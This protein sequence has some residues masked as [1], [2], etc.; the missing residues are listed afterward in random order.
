MDCVRRKRTAKEREKK[1][2]RLIKIVV[3]QVG[4]LSA[5]IGIGLVDLHLLGNFRIV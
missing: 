3:S 1:G 4:I 2:K 5:T